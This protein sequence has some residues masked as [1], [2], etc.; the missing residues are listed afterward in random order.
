MYFFDY[1]QIKKAIIIKLLLQI[2]LFTS[3]NLYLINKNN[4][5]LINFKKKGSQNFPNFPI[6]RTLAIINV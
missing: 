6:S 3:M 5:F 4:K 2:F 1:L